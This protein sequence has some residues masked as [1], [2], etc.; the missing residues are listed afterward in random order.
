MTASSCKHH[1]RRAGNINSPAWILLF[2]HKEN[3][4]HLLSSILLKQYSSASHRPVANVSTTSTGTMLAKLAAIWLVCAKMAGWQS[5][6]SNFAKAF[7]GQQDSWGKAKA[8]KWT[9]L[10]K[11]KKVTTNNLN[12]VRETL[13]FM[14]HEQL[15]LR[16]L[17]SRRAQI[18]TILTTKTSQEKWACQ[19]PES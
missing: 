14:R 10:K 13:V 2:Y 6:L 15:K 5:C 8:L 18:F 7:Y 9:L 12:W 17:S 1:K 4:Q 19:H 3:L 16:D 11:K